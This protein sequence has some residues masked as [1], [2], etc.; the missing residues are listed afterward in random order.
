[1][2]EFLVSICTGMISFMIGFIFGWFVVDLFTQKNLKPFKN[3]PCKQSFKP[4]KNMS[5][6]K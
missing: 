4:S 5:C 3:K 6:N 1:M 2:I